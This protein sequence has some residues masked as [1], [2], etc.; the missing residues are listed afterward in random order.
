MPDTGEESAWP[1]DLEAHFEDVEIGIARTRAEYDG[2]PAV[3]EIEQLF[4]RQI[5]SAR[6]F[7]YAE[8][9][10]LTSRVICEAIA[11]RLAEPDPPEIVIVMP[12]M[13]EGW[14]EDQAMSP[15]RAELVQS[16]QE[17]DKTGRFHIYVPYSGE[18][19]IYVH[20]KLTIIDDRILRIGSANM[21]NRSLGL[22]SEC[23]VFIDCERPGNET[24][25]ETIHK[26]RLSLLAEHLGMREESA[27]EALERHGSMS[28][29]IA[30]AGDRTH[31]HLRPF[32]PELPEGLLADMAQRQTLDPESPDEMFTLHDDRRGLFR[33]G[34]LLSRARARLKRKQKRKD[35]DE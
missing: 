32:N 25:C 21:N 5:A 1:D 12:E 17:L 9:Q 16:L 14:L 7:I 23:D 27:G 3:D 24:A 13:A 28:A 20:A 18:Q 33:R 29:L 19:N 34:S 10:Y 26:L 30:A 6:N 35:G 15:A 11:K 8:N 2:C 22:D 31:R 4:V